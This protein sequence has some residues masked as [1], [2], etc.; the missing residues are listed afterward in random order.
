MLYKTDVGRET[1]DTREKEEEEEEEALLA[2]E[3]TLPFLFSLSDAIHAFLSPKSV[4][5]NRLPLRKN[6]NEI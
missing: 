4:S 6:K 2:L 5:V 1:L 3:N